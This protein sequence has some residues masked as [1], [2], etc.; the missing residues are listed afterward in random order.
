MVLMK[1]FEEVIDRLKEIKEAYFKKR[2]AANG[3]RIEKKTRDLTR[4]HKE[5][6]INSA[7]RKN[8]LLQETSGKE[9]EKKEAEEKEKRLIEEEV[10]KKRE[11]ADKK[12]AE[13]N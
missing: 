6:F 4:R 3:R 11:E 5:N 7:L 9:H 10:R 2:A 8:K 13:E 12:E 1:I